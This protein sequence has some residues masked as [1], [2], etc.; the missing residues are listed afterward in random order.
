MFSSLISFC[1]F[2]NLSLAHWTDYS[3][4]S[5]QTHPWLCT[6]VTHLQ[7]GERTLCT[8]GRH[9]KKEGDGG[10]YRGEQMDLGPSARCR[11]RL[12]C[13]CSVR[14]NWPTSWRPSCLPQRWILR[15]LWRQTLWACWTQH[16]HDWQI[17][18]ALPG[19]SQ[20]QGGRRNNVGDQK[21]WTKD[22]ECTDQVLGEEEPLAETKEAWKS[23]RG[24]R[25]AEDLALQKSHCLCL[26]PFDTT[27]SN[28][29]S[30]VS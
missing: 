29:S 27:L 28:Y 21:L 6:M 5:E 16:S 1:I 24:L 9:Y 11:P 30:L 20:V 13:S 14:N 8:Q 7:S 26:S 2:S 23:F 25:W 15:Q 18:K 10:N 19:Q 4:K 22:K 17:W 3:F 12:P